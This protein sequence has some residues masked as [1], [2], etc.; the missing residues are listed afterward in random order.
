MDCDDID[1]YDSFVPIAHP[2]SLSCRSY[3]VPGY[4]IASAKLR[5]YSG[6]S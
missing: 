6:T 3:Q 1:R 5:C 2:P 4:Y